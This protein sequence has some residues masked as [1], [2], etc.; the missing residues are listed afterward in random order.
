MPNADFPTDDSPLCYCFGI[1]MNDYRRDP[2]LKDVVS[3]KTKAGLCSCKT[4]NPSGNCC[5]K[6]FPELAASDEPAAVYRFKVKPHPLGVVAY[7]SP[8]QPGE[9]LIPG[10]NCCGI[11]VAEL[12]RIAANGGTVEVPAEQSQDCPLR[13]R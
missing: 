3:A 6:D 10:E 7:Q 8:E 11:P 2:S 13:K 9:L 4:M 5:L 12:A 1:S